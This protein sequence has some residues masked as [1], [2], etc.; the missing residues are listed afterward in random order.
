MVEKLLQFA[1]DLRQ[2]AESL[3]HFAERFAKW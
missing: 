1:E 3:L 2:M